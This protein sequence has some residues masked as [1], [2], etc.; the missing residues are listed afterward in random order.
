[1]PTTFRPYAPGQDLLQAAG[2]M[3][4]GLRELQQDAS[5]E[6]SRPA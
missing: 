6:V 4:Q 2:G 5:H 1:M 3:R